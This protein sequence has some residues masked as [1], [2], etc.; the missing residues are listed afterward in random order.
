MFGSCVVAFDGRSIELFRSNLN[1]KS[2]WRSHC[3]LVTAGPVGPPDRRGL[4]E[5][6]FINRLDRSKALSLH[7][8]SAHLPAVQVVLEALQAAG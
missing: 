5:V 6:P 4:V 2:V 1:A 7:V 8:P 3:A